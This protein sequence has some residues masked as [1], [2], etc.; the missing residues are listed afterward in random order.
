MA[1]ASSGSVQVQP[2]HVGRPGDV[3]PRRRRCASRSTRRGRICPRR[4]V[5]R[6]CTASTAEDRAELA[7]RGEG[8]PRQVGGEGGRVRRHRAANRA[9]LP[10]LPP[11]GRGE[12]RHGGL[13]RQGDGRAHLPRLQR[14]AGAARPGCCSPSRAR[15]STTSAS[16]T[17]TSCTRSS[18]PSSRPAA[19][20]TPAGRCSR[21]SAA[22]WNCSWA[23]A[24]TT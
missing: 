7:A 13:A 22:G 3:Q 20:P 5:T 11:A 12:L 1:A 14:R 21:R 23:S 8:Q 10:P 6:S 2:G 9:A 19:G 15:P 4:R 17:S 18:A 16:C 24:W